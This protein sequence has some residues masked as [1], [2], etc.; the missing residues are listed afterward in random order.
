MRPLFHV[1]YVAITSSLTKKDQSDLGTAILS[2]I[3]LVIKYS[4]EIRK[5]NPVIWRFNWQNG[6]NE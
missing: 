3:S 2:K 1:D 4:T 6:Q 5:I